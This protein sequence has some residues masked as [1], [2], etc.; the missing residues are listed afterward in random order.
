M[1]A[2][3]SHINNKYIDH[4][5]DAEVCVATA[6]QREWRLDLPERTV[7]PGIKEAAAPLSL[8]AG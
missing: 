4:K 2:T 8:K 6:E 3:W 1:Q 7:L 5:L